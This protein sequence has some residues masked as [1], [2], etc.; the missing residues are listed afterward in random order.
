MADTSTP[1]TYTLTNVSDVDNVLI[2][3][4]NRLNAKK[5]LID[6]AEFS[7]NRVQDLNESYRKRY[8][9]YNYIAVVVVIVLLI[10][11]G[12]VILQYF[13][14]II[15]TLLVDLVTIFVFAFIIIFVV[16]HLIIVYSRD[17]L[18]FDKINMENS[19]I[20]SKEEL[21]K[22]REKDIASGNLSA[23]AGIDI[24]NNCIGAACCSTGTQWDAGNLVCMSGNV[25]SGFTTINDSFSGFENS[26]III[27][28]SL[29][30]PFKPSEFDN[31]AKI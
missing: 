15:P 13:F 26:D 10:Y 6:K 28:G 18:N 30:T 21:N 8:I 24:G 25:I 3:E 14:P 29:V 4:K 9:Y 1:S 22:Q 31:Y 12:L 5:E 19:N 27:N 17:R 16:Y 7:Q 20:I 23:V 2:N 11:L